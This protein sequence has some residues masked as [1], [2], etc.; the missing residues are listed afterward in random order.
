MESFTLA[1]RGG[2]LALAQ[3]EIISNALKR[4]RPNIQIK[5]K[6]VT[7]KGDLDRRTFLWKLKSSGFF[8]SVLEDS[9]LSGRAGIAVHSFKD[10]PTQKREGLTIAAVCDRTFAEDCLIAAK[11]VRSI[12]EMPKSAT[13][14]TS[15]LRRMVQIKHLR[16]DLRAIPVRGNV[17][18]RIQLVGQGK[19]NAVI[20]ARAGIER[21]GLS[22][23]ISFCFDPE[24]F[25]PAPAQGA[26]CV[27]TRDDDNAA[28][29]VV[30]EID[31]KKIRTS[32]LAER[33][34]LITMQCGCHAPVGAFAQIKNG[35]IQIHAFIADLE[36]KNFIKRQ[37]KGPID[38][39]IELAEKIANDLL[40]AGGKEI[41][42]ELKTNER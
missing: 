5:I 8:T 26:L 12:H 22:G 37:I 13:I 7:T 31:D 17:T 9:L 39:A 33:Q 23:K 21:L 30:A 42:E 28:S 1:T 25:I 19:Y 35:E 4:Q 36:G 15:S 24:Q 3:A 20:L 11:K 14:G 38:K 32:T 6:T 41:L 10:L 18:T 40:N 29:Q 27:Q 16:E 34:V 2:K